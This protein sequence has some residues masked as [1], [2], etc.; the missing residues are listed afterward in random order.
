MK[1]NVEILTQLSSKLNSLI[2]DE[3]KSHIIEQAVAANEWFTRVG[4]HSAIEAITTHML[5]ERALE[6]WLCR[7][8][9]LCQSAPRD[10]ATIMAGNIPLVGLHDLIC[11]IAVGHSLWVK[12][13]SKDR[14]LMEWVIAT[15]KE[16]EPSIPIYNYDEEREYNAVIAT[17]GESAVRYFRS[18]YA[19][20]KILLRGNRHSIAVLDGSETQDELAALSDDIYTHSGL[21][22]RNVSMIFAPKGH[23]LTIEGREVATG[24]RNNYR[25]RRAVMQICA[26]EYYDNGTSLFVASRELPSH[27][28]TISVYK[29]ESLHEVEEW[30]AQ[31]DK[32]LQCIV[33]NAVRHPRQVAFGKAQYP[34][35]ADYADGVDTIEFLTSI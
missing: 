33:T 29:Y 6:E 2:T 19:S 34:S 32:Q 12:P 13:S 15:L 1:K 22:C 8:P 24:Y 35:L 25:Q 3:S 10:V 30:I 26:S 14:V 18:R 5:G 27:L 4:I 16:I 23:H 31:H 28:S 20:T 21:G 11:A 7:Y 9:A 17:G